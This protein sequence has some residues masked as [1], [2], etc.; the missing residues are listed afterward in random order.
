MPTGQFSHVALL[1]A[2]GVSL[3]LPAPHIAHPVLFVFANWPGVHSSQDP[4]SV[5]FACPE[6]HELHSRELMAP[7]ICLPG[8]H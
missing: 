6:S 8:P 3:H 5:G 4:P 1:L 7:L 2:P